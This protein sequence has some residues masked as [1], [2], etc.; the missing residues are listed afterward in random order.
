V[1]LR[2]ALSTI[3][4]GHGYE[5]RHHFIQKFFG[6]SGA[7][8]RP[9]LSQYVRCNS[10]VIIPG[11]KALLCGLLGV[12]GFSGTVPATRLA[13]TDMDPTFLALARAVG[14]GV[15]AVI[16]LLLRREALP[17]RR[18]LGGLALV[19]LGTVITF[20]LLMAVALTNIPAAEAAMVLAF[21]PTL[22]ALCGVLQGAERPPTRFW[23]ANALGLAAVLWFLQRAPGS[24][25]WG[26]ALLA[27]ACVLC[28]VGYTAG[29]RLAREMPGLTVVSWALVLSLPLLAPVLA[30]LPVPHQVPAAA[31]LGLSYVT[32]IS[33]FLAFAP[34]YAALARGGIALTSQLQLLQPLL[35][36]CWAA[37][38]LGEATSAR[39]WITLVVVIGAIVWSRRR[40]AAAVPS[41]AQRGEHVGQRLPLLRRILL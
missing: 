26:H 35:S 22:T 40:S 2:F 18:Q 37:L 28:A 3:T 19:A 33:M 9:V 14:A 10:N 36:V 41:L 30:W 21:I 11:G 5:P 4:L 15:I 24:L 27:F 39:L 17:A 13:V 31:W 29:A 34:W 8:A 7:R 32:V 20:P 6:E 16:F 12:L 23:L 38:L 1:L 25:R